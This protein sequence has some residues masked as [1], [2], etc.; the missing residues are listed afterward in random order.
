MVFLLLY[1]YAIQARDL[2]SDT[3]VNTTHER[4]YLGAPLGT[5]VFLHQ[6]VTE[7]NNWRQELVMLSD[8][9][10]AQPHPAH[11]AFTHGYIRKFC[12]FCR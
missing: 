9:A 4:P 7:V 1:Y 5:N 8:I 12:D 6:F 11:S 2:F 3:Q 10:K